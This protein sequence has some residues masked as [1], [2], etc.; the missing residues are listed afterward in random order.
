[1]TATIDLDRLNDLLIGLGRSLLQY[2][3]EAWPWTPETD[4]VD[5]RGAIERLAARQQESVRELAEFLD[6]AG[7]PV[8][9][10]VYPEEF[11]SLHYVSLRYLLHRIVVNQQA[12][13]SQCEQT[14]RAAADDPD[15]AALL[16][17]IVRREREIL[18]E[19]RQLAAA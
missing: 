14:A 12:V 11:T 6:A 5:R 9:F 17:G 1:M 18:A 15:A 10:G 7:H 16:E 8:R 13:V 2:T 19:L 3:Q 4:G